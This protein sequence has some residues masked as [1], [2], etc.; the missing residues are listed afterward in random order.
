MVV[1]EVLQQRPIKKSQSTMIFLKQATDETSSVLGVKDKSS[2]MIQAKR[3]IGKHDMKENV[4]AKVEQMQKEV[5]QL[6]GTFKDMFEKWI[7][8]FWDGNG[9]MILKGKYDSLSEEIRI[10]HAKFQD[11]EE[12]LK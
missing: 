8:S 1:E 12:N 3:F 10:D 6:K 4:K 9:K 2:I 11:M 7:P 5:Q